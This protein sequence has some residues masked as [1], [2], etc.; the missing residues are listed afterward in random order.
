MSLT[1]TQRDCGDQLL[2]IGFG[3]RLVRASALITALP[4]TLAP[5]SYAVSGVLSMGGGIGQVFSG[6]Y[7]ISAAAGLVW[8]GTGYG[9]ADGW[10][11]IGIAG[12]DGVRL[13][14]TGV[15]EPGGLAARA[16]SGAD[17]WVWVFHRLL[18]AVLTASGSIGLWLLRMDNRRLGRDGGHHARKSWD[19]PCRFFCW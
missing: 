15:N 10:L 16:I 4:G 1:D 6:T 7:V 18:R 8:L 19:N 2:I 5:G 12:H 9:C 3:G 14:D 13:L 17:E 11:C